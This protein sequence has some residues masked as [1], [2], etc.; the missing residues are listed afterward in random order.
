MIDM[1]YE[2][3]CL[4]EY[5]VKTKKILSNPLNGPYKYKRYQSNRLVFALN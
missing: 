2:P 1:I 3:V 4:L 5:N